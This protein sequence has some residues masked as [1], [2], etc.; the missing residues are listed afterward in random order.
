MNDI[1]IS[2]EFLV[3]MLVEKHL[4]CDRRSYQGCSQHEAEEA[5]AYSIIPD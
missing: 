3:T 4:Q 5:T 2:V 1:T